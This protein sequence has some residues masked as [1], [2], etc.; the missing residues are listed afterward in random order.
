MLSHAPMPRVWPPTLSPLSCCQGQG[1][2]ACQHR[3]PIPSSQMTVE[4]SSSPCQCDRGPGLAQVCGVAQMHCRDTFLGNTM[5]QYGPGQQGRLMFLHTNLSP[6]WN[7]NLPGSFRDYT[8]RWQV[9]APSR[10]LPMRA[11][12][13]IS[14]GNDG[15]RCSSPAVCQLMLLR[16]CTC[17]ADRVLFGVPLSPQGDGS[18]RVILPGGQTP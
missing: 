7:L 15:W 5:T 12:C 6:K 11:A 3:S 2:L 8:R 18:S 13:A 17:Q 16:H 9:R 14:C 1:G 4:P 10:R